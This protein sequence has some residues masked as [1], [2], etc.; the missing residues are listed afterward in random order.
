MI[1]SIALCSAAALMLAACSSPAPDATAP[2]PA[3][4]PVTSPALTTPVAD[5]VL[6]SEGL[7]ALRI[8]MTLAEVTA[9][10]GADSEPN[11]VGGADPASCDQ[12]RPERSPVGTLVMIE[13]G[14]LTRISLI[15]GSTIKTNRGFGVG[16]SAE[17]VRTAYGAGATST[18]HKYVAAPA[19]YITVWTKGGSTDGSYVQDAAA[20]GIVYETNAEGRVQ[21]VH[22]GGPS[23][24]LVEGCS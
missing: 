2:D 15:N 18:P 9:A 16:D 22:A 21:M 20:R 23:I 12:F 8:G 19:G 3:A 13:N 1:R 10:A 6:T 4:P 11:A 14:I 7:G 17:A 24:Q 5:N